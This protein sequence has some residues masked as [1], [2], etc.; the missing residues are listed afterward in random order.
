MYISVERIRIKHH[1]S[2][3][4]VVILYIVAFFIAGMPHDVYAGDDLSLYA[5]NAVLIDGETG[6]I[7]Y[8]KNGSVHHPNASTTKILTCII[9][10]ECGDLTDTVIASSYAA[11]MPEVRLGVREGEI[12]NLEDMLYAMML[13]SY[14]DAA[15]V[16]AE[17]IGGDVQHFA[18][19]MNSKAKEIGCRT[20]YFITP[21]GLD[22]QDEGGIHGTSAE[23][24]ARI[25][26]YC[27]ITSPKSDLFLEITRTRFYTFSDSSGARS[28]AC[29]NHNAFLDM[30]DEALS[31]KTGF[32]CDA[33]YCY[34][35]A[36]EYDGHTYIWA[37]LGC[38]WP[39]NKTYKWKDSRTL[40]AYAEKNASYTEIA[41]PKAPDLNV[42]FS[43]KS[44]GT[45][46]CPSVC[47]MNIT[48]CSTENE[49][50]LDD[51]IIYKYDILDTVAAPI[52]AGEIVGWL[53]VY[54]D[55]KLIDIEPVYIKEN[56]PDIGIKDELLR[57]FEN[58]FM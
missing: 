2:D 38:G 42:I 5:E 33:G 48:I 37:L 58:A 43:S 6:D 22:A 25:M 7:L 28:F 10:L 9:A 55:G 20:T 52:T 23:D 53:G 19:M 8:E 14:N 45:A 4:I 32:T 57:V 12:F 36:A 47:D 56:L 26:R 51:E 13:E 35:G 11:K 49:Q 15:V 46:R 1:L 17:H 30:S 54:R 3:L 34:I 31:G 24:L 39:N 41:A 16:I 44:A 21:N 27:I 50:V 18:D 29:S 40:L